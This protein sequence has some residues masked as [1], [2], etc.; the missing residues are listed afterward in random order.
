M[1]ENLNIKWVKEGYYSQQSLKHV[2]QGASCLSPCHQQCDNI[3]HY[4][5]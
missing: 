4:N 5:L 2:Q 1:W 3:P